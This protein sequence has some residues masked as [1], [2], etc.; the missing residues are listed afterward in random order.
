MLSDR[1]GIKNTFADDV[2]HFIWDR[3]LDDNEVDM[4]LAFSD[5]EIANAMR[6]TSL[7]FNAI[8]PFSITMSG[9][10]LPNT[11]WALHGVTYHLLLSRYHRESRNDISYN[12]GGVTTDRQ[13]TLIS[14]IKEQMQ[15]HREEFY[16]QA[17][18]F[19]FNVNI[20]N[21]YDVNLG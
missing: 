16:S 2:R 19:K 18:D 3:S 6:H 4:D 9:L 12:A 11:S 1:D 17:R 15:Y 20:E 21:S 14:H 7:S 10:G 13:K 5:E 8:K